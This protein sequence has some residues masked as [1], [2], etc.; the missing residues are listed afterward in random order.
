MDRELSGRLFRQLDSFTMTYDLV[1][2]QL[3]LKIIT[4][5]RAS[6]AV[7]EYGEKDIGDVCVGLQHRDI[8]PRR[9]AMPRFLC[10]VLCIALQ[11]CSSTPTFQYQPVVAHLRE[12]GPYLIQTCKPTQHA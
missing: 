6:L 3:I 1:P 2:S 4:R 10:T 11:L 9:G 5:R 8:F 7:I 12:S